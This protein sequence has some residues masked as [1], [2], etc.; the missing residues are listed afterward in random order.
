MKAVVL[1]AGR[2]SRLGDIQGNKCMITVNGRHVIE[3]SFDCASGTD[4]DEM[5]V[6]VGY[7]AEEIIN[8]YGNCYKGMRIKYAVQQEQR[9]L[10]HALECCRPMLGGDDFILLLGDEVLINPRHQELI[11]AFRNDE[12]VALCGVLRVEDRS[13]IKRTYSILHDNGGKIY[14]LIEK[15]RNPLNDI[16]GTGDCVFRNEILSYIEYT[17]I[18]YER[19]E[20]EL[21]D[22]IQSAID[23]GKLVKSFMICDRYTNI[24]TPEDIA[25]AERFFNESSCCL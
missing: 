14:R 20:K 18:H 25:I 19:K 4:V 7:R 16:M 12:A 8:T 2:G 9:G 6:V 11:N 10:V 23:D 3:Y 24:N 15:P 17:P 1:A 13:F 21:P 22:L 5:V